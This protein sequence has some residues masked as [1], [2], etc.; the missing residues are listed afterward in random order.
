MDNPGTSSKSETD[1]PKTAKESK[2][3]SIAYKPSKVKNNDE[4][5]SAILKAPKYIPT[6]I[7]KLE[8]KNS[9]KQQKQQN[10]QPV[11]SNLAKELQKQESLRKSKKKSERKQSITSD[12]KA[13]EVAKSSHKSGKDK[14]V[15]KAE[16]PVKTVKEGNAG[17]NHLETIDLFAVNTENTQSSDDETSCMEVEPFPVA[18]SCP[19]FATVSQPLSYINSR[20]SI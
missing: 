12:S 10:Q 6:P 18:S 5:A 15:A 16:K 3:K 2:R 13:V 11:K 17:G 19:E 8:K 7:A 20:I 14:K 1:I 4:A 9:A